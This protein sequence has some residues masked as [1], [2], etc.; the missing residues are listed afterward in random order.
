MK[1][2]VSVLICFCMIM[3]L[4]PLVVL[5]ESV[6][7]TDYSITSME[8]AHVQT[9]LAGVADVTEI[10]VGGNTAVK[11]KLTSNLNGRL[12]IGDNGWDDWDGNF[13]LDLNG[14]TID[15]GRSI[16]EAICLDNDFEGKFTITGSGSMKAGFNHIIYIGSAEVLFAVA[17]GHD[18]FTLKNSGNDLFD[19]KNTETKS[20]WSNIGGDELVMTQGKDVEGIVFSYAY[21]TRRS[22]AFPES[23]GSEITLRG[24]DKPLKR[25][26]HSYD[27]SVGTWTLSEVGSYGEASSFDPVPNMAYL[28]SIVDSVAEEY[29]LSD[30]GKDGIL[31]HKL[32]DES[33]ELVAY[34]VVI[35]V[36]ATRGYTLFIGDVWGPSGA[37]YV[38]S[39]SE[40]T[41][42]SVTFNA[43][44][45]AESVY[46]VSVTPTAVT[47]V[48]AEEGYTVPDGETVTIANTGNVPT[49]ALS[50]AL[51][52]GSS[53][54]FTLS[55]SSIADIA[56]DGS[57]VVTV[58]PN[59]GLS[60]GTYT[61]TITVSGE[62]V[63]TQT[64]TVS[65]TVT[66][67]A[68]APTPTPTPTPGGKRRPVAGLPTNK[69]EE[70]EVKVE[71]PVVD[72]CPGVTFKDLDAS[73]WYHEDVDYV[74]ENEIMNGVSETEFAPNENLTRAMLVTILYRTEGE[75]AT[76]RS[77]PFGDVDLG[78]YYGSAVIWA[79]QNGIIMGISETEFAPEQ[80]VTREQLATIMFRYAA[81][82]GMN[83]VTMEENLHFE[84][85]AD[86]S[87]YAITAMNWSVGEDYI[88]I[89]NEG[90]INPTKTA[91]R[92]EVAAF[93]HR[94][95]EDSKN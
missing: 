67:V 61:E 73:A 93:I 47:F 41:E 84:D 79:K 91:T 5:A 55:K 40:I 82:K 77:I 12:H 39:T 66:Q 71:E 48:D 30:E 94:Y 53:S 59:S 49:G 69:V 34:G 75:P 95:M 6:S 65:F 89:R 90:E 76:N 64:A 15:A 44:Q 29:D 87:E 63:M 86:I 4:L 10:T 78:E 58:V 88:F 51:S 72:E 46:A 74:I 32:S 2:I 21:D 27:T 56:V 80:E 3:T 16:Q 8:L 18:Y 62:M 37:G 70:P 57:D 68:P 26:D 14:K 92:A 25:D 38:L 42:Y 9:A 43:E 54:V 7:Y 60:A 20:R 85:A 17:G 50:I 35:G 28:D 31:I 23:I 33:G 83:A 11:I 22:P 24:F 13:I 81:F 45:L 19:E 52:G 36:D 1:K